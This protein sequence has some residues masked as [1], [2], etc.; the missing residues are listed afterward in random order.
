MIRQLGIIALGLTTAC[1]GTDA[2]PSFANDSLIPGPPLPAL[3]VFP[4]GN[5]WSTD[6]ST[7]PVDTASDSLIARCGANAQLHPDFGTWYDGALFGIPFVTVDASQPKVPVTFQYDD[8]SDPGPYPIP[9]RAPIEGGSASHGDRHVIV[10][11]VDDWKLYELFDAHPVNGGA[12]WTAGSGAIFDLTTGAL[13][14][15]GWT[16][17]D[18]AG[19]PIFAGLVRYDEAVVAGV[20]THAL[21]FT[22][23][24]T[25]RA[26]VPPARHEAGS[27][28]SVYAPPMGMRVRLK[29]GVDISGFA[30]EVRAILQALKTYGMFLADNGSPFFLS[31]APDSLWNDGHI[32]QLKQLH[33][34][35]FEVVQMTGL[36]I[37]PAPVP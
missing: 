36:V 8:E 24:V 31:G 4:A 26:W 21:R 7:A 11:D 12:S 17:A 29:A 34:R 10:V 33:G 2:G 18:A 23:P 37:A 16:S 27:S 15:D 5:P 6:I 9:S 1:S 20:I 35:D 30:P 3:T 14:P 13:R 32:N 28:N 19:L 25:R 22:C